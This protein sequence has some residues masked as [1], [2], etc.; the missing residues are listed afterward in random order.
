MLTKFRKNG[1]K[2]QQYYSLFISCIYRKG[3]MYRYHYIVIIGNRVSVLEIQT[4][5]GLSNLNSTPFN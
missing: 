1:L 3:S 4:Y 2:V 5:G